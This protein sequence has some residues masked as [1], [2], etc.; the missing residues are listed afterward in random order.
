MQL[1]K[2]NVSHTNIVANRGKLFVIEK[3]SSHPTLQ[4]LA[5]AFITYRIKKQ[6]PKGGLDFQLLKQAVS[7]L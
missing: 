6:V 5:K 7:T 1:V 4:W 2:R 3:H